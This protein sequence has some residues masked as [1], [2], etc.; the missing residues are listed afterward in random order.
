MPGCHMHDTIK[1]GLDRMDTDA[2]MVLDGNVRAWATA[3]ATTNTK[4][5]HNNFPTKHGWRWAGASRPWSR[6]G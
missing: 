5:L 3:R 1:I 6:H 2:D 4:F